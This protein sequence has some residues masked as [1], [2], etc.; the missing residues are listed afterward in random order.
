[1]IWKYNK[2]Y[3]HIFDE[4]VRREYQMRTH[5]F[6]EL[7]RRVLMEK[8]TKIFHGRAYALRINHSFFF[9]IIFFVYTFRFSSE[10]VHVPERLANSKQ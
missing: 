2:N 6:A 8:Q 7:H 1:M 10:V 4:R 5:K 9:C 3:S